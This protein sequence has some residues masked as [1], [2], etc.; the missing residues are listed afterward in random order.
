MTNTYLTAIKS[1][2]P[3]YN[4]EW[5]I[6]PKW[7]FRLY[8]RIP[9]TKSQ[10]DLEGFDEI[11][12]HVFLAKDG[13]DGLSLLKKHGIEIL[14][15]PVWY[16]NRE[17]HSTEDLSFI[18]E[19]GAV[20][21]DAVNIDNFSKKPYI[22]K[23]VDLHQTVDASVWASEFCKV[24]GKLYKSNIDPEWVHSWMC[25]ALMCGW[26]HQSW[27]RDKEYIYILKTCD[28]DILKV[29]H[30]EPTEKDIREEYVKHYPEDMVGKDYDVW[31]YI[32]LYRWSRS[33]GLTEMNGP[34]SDT[35][36][37]WKAVNQ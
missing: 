20:D 35:Q 15:N 28:G 23:D 3:I 32:R 25:N 27:K 34:K 10:M 36:Y 12:D 13:S 5:C 14:D 4:N 31:N 33:Y 9:D 30:W 11:M 24:F 29:F 18:D 1:K 8:G 19:D 17:H 7:Y 21:W 22:Q 16:Y 26:D 2:N 37:E 6:T